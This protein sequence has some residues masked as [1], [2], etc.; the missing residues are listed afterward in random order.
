MKI[1]NNIFSNLRFSWKYMCDFDLFA[2][3]AYYQPF[4][5]AQQVR[6]TLSIS[7]TLKAFPE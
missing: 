5:V 2:S 3:T 6:K 7:S 1:V 4:S